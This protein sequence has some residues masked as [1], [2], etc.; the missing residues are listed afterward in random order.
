VN[1][2][3]PLALLFVPHWVHSLL[4]WLSVHWGDVVPAWLAV[5]VAGVFGWVSWRSSRRSKAAEEAAKQQANRATEAAE[6]AVAA[7][8]QIAGETKRLAD[9]A[10]QQVDAKERRPWDIK[11]DGGY[12]YYRL[13]NK[14]DTPK[15]D[16]YLSGDRVMGKNHFRTIDG[17]GSKP[18]VLLDTGVNRTGQGEM[19]ADAGP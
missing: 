1:R 13:I 19:A 7:Q 6:K 2:L 3:V 15:Y 12:G 16:V 17:G 14:R 5:I 8:K 18:V 4:Y 9:V 10:E 11:P